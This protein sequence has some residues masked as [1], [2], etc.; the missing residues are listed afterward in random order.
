MQMTLLAA[1]YFV[2]AKLSLLTAIPPGYA[3]SV[4]PPSGLAL[5]AVLLRLFFALIYTI[6]EGDDIF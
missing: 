6:D 3:T 2:L 5:A 4:W 1:L